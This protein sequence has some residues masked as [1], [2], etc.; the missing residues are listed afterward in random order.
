M[1]PSSQEPPTGAIETP[2]HIVLS[3]AKG[4]VL[5]GPAGVGG[6][7]PPGSARRHLARSAGIIALGNISSR[8]LGLVREVVIADLFGA[9]GL[10][11]AFR[12]AST[13]RR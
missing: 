4:I 7:A 11:S 5:T 6:T 13:C 8:V 10:V 9:S 12:I 1:E 2:P 3:P